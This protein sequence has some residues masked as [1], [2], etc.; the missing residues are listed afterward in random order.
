MNVEYAEAAWGKSGE[1][2]AEVPV[3]SEE[4]SGRMFAWYFFHWMLIRGGIPFT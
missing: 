1:G 2:M 4:S 3:T